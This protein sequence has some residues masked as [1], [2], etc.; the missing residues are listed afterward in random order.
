MSERR[1]QRI[2]VT[3]REILPDQPIDI[4][5]T[6]GDSIEAILA[7]PLGDEFDKRQPR[8]NG[9]VDR[10]D[11]ILSITNRAVKIT[12]AVDSFDFFVDGIRYTKEAA[13]SVEFDDQDGD[14][15]V[16]YDETGTLQWGEDF[17]PLIIS[18]Y[19]FVAF[20]YWS[21]ADQKAHLFLDERHGASMSSTTHEYLH[22]TR[23]T[24]LETGLGLTS[25]SADASGND[26]TS[27]QYAVEGGIIWDE[28]IRWVIADG[29]PQDISPI[30]K[31]PVFHLT[32]AGVWTSETATDY[33]VVTTGT[34][35]LAWNEN[36]AG[37]WQLTEVGNNSFVC[38][39]TVAST[40]IFNPVFVLCGQAEYG[41]VAAAQAGALTEVLDLELGALAS[42]STE[43][44]L[45]ATTIWQ[46][47]NSY[48]NAV[49]GRIR[50]TESG[51]DYLDWRDLPRTA[52]GGGGGAA[53]WGGISGTLADQTDLQAELDL[54]LETW[55]QGTHYL[56]GSTAIYITYGVDGDWEAT[57][58]TTSGTTSTGSGQT[59]T[60]PTT[61][62][63]LQ[64][65]SYS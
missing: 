53:V 27:A 60:K 14:K 30:A 41:N 42:L 49:Q 55:E 6:L 10:A 50:S 58:S 62:A 37:T 21:V 35:R 22:L 25:I 12:P 1:R 15:Y 61:L 45:I 3:P 51:D 8:E 59:G 32:S 7:G 36:V 54:K 34:G 4:I 39:H 24:Q 63:A 17:D 2:T 44:V 31:L 64:A 9:F 33:P 48:S 38:Y 65:L 46:T 52:S 29:T 43:W 11:A 16:F 57:K 28:D 5:G 47:S 23:G 18:R 19:A 26:A 40:D 20:V 56:D 13:E